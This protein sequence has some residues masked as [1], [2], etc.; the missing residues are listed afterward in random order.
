MQRQR[1]AIAALLGCMVCTLAFL[2]AG[3]ATP[4]VTRISFQIAT[5]P[6]G[7]SYF[8]VGEALARIIS[9]PPGFGRCEDF[10]DICGPVGLMASARS[11]DGPIANIAA[12]RS[13]RVASALIQGDVASLAYR[14][15]GPFRSAGAFKE[16]RV[17]A[18]LQRETVHLVVSSRSRVKRLS[19]LKGKRIGIDAPSTATHLTARAILSA[20]KLNVSKLRLSFQPPKQAVADLAAGKIDAFFI[21]GA[22]P[23]HPVD[24]LVRG[25]S[26]RVLPIEGKAIAG[27]LK[28]QPFLA[29]VELPAGTYHEAKATR[30]LAVVAL[31]VA[32]A[33]LP[34]TVAYSLTRA[35]WNPTNRVELDSLGA[36]GA[37]I[38]RDGRLES[39]PVP[40]HAGAAKFY[41]DA[42]RLQN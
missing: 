12:V 40:L 31:W 42:G 26:A 9:N 41:Q 29:T 2:G 39:S 19:D 14:G 22:A 21:I 8:P 38:R 5:G 6:V 17:L 7:G 20:A 23:L 1:N 11:T 18:T 3:A 36:V 33:K 34:D 10:V 28:T 37:T 27:W 24:E 35:L 32:T 13:G 25:S 16:M 30:T 15:S 4:E